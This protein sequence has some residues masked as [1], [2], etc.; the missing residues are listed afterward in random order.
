MK[1]TTT[2]VLTAEDQ[3]GPERRQVLDACLRFSFPAQA[4]WDLPT[5]DK[6]D[7]EIAGTAYGSVCIDVLYR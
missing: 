5:F 1:L 4:A 2:A 6:V 3:R 7:G